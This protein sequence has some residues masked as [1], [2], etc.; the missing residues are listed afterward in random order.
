MKKLL[1]LLV[2]ALLTSAFAQQGVLNYNSNQ[3][4][5][6]PK[7]VDELL[8]QM[9]MEQNPDIELNHTQVDHEGFKQAIRTYFASSTPPEVLT[10]FA[11]NRMRF[12]ADRDVLLNIDDVWIDNGWEDAYPVGFQASS[13]YDGEYVFVPASYYWWAIYYRKDVFND[14][15]LTEPQ[16]WDELLTVCDTLSENG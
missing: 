11:G 2:C 1:V 5:P 12:F 13:Q 9:F 7:R 10:W 16:T 15:G 4:D 14:L 6:E 3:S 8:V